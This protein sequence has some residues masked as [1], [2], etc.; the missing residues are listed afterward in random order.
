MIY[1]VDIRETDT[2][3]TNDGTYMKKIADVYYDE[4]R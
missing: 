4:T 2:G 3:N 1:C